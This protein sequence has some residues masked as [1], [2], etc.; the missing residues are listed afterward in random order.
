MI[1]RIGR[2]EIQA[3][4]GRGGFGHV[5]R[6]FDP[7]M[8]SLVAIKRLSGG[9]PELLIRFRNEAAAARKLQHRNIVTVYDFGEEDGVPYIVMELLD[10]ADLQRVIANRQPLSV[11]EKI[12]IMSQVAD[13]LNYAHT[14]GVV[15]R[16]VK[17][18]NIML[19]ADG[20]VKIMD[21]GIALV[22]KATAPRFTPTGMTVG[23]LRYMAPEQ[24]E[25]TVSDSLCDIFSY[26]LV[27]YELLTGTHPFDAAEPAGVIGKILRAEP[28]RIRELCPS[29]P[30]GLEQVV[31]RLLQKERDLRYQSLEDVQFDIQPILLELQRVRGAE[32][33]TRAKDLAARGQVDAAQGLL[34]EILRDDPGNAEARELHGTLQVQAQRKAV[35]ARVEG[36][37]K[38]GQEKMAEQDYGAA[39]ENFESALRLDKLNSDIQALIQQARGAMEQLQRARF[40]VEEAQRALDLRDLT[41]AYQ[42]ATEAL[43]LDPRNAQATL[44]MGEVLREMASRERERRLQQA[45]SRAKG[46]LMLQ[47]FD[48]AISLLTQLEPDYP[49]SRE[50]SELLER[51]RRDKL[52]HERRERL[53]A[54]IAAAKDLL[55]NK[56]PAEAVQRLEQLALDF[57]ETAEVRDLLSYAREELASQRR[58]EKLKQATDEARAL[59]D[60]REFDRAMEILSEALRSFPGEESLSYLLQTTI[61]SKAAFERQAALEEAL[62]NV[63][64]FLAENNYEEALRRIDAFVVWHGNDPA[65]SE[66]RKRARAEWE[67]Q[68]RIQAAGKMMSEARDLL[69]KD[70]PDLATRILRGAKA[71]D[72]DNRELAAL[73][74]IAETRLVEQ[75]RAETVRKV[76]S[77]AAE[78]AGTGQFDRAELLVQETQRQYPQDGALVRCLEATRLARSRY[79]QEQ[80]RQE[81]I[82][83]G[84]QLQREGR[85][86]E[87]ASLIEALLRV[88]PLDPE[89]LTL[90]AA[91][92]AELKE[93]REEVQR[94]SN[95]AR[96][97]MGQH[98]FEPVISL[99]EEHLRRF[100]G[101]PELSLL[102]AQSREL[103]ARQK[104]EEPQYRETAPPPVQAPPV[105]A[106]APPMAGS[107]LR[108]HGRRVAVIAAAAVI[109]GLSIT[110][111]YQRMHPR[112]PEKAPSAELT[113]PIETKSAP[114]KEPIEKPKPENKKAPTA[115]T[116]TTGPLTEERDQAPAIKQNVPAH[117]PLRLRGGLSP[118]AGSG[119]ASGP[120]PDLLP[121][122]EGGP[123]SPGSLPAA[124]QAPP[125]TQAFPK[126]GE[127]N[128]DQLAGTFNL[129]G[130][131]ALKRKDYAGAIAKFTQAIQL[132]PDLAAYYFNRGGT[133][134]QLGS[135]KEAVADFDKTL[136]LEPGNPV[137]TK[138]RNEARENLAA[139]VYR[140]G[141]GVSTPI[142]LQTVPA[143]PTREA[144]HAGTKLPPVKL[145]FVVNERG[146]TE[147]FRIDTPSPYGL[148]Q[149]AI[150]A[151]R[152]WKFSPGKKDGKP[153]AVEVVF[154]VPFKGL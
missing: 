142:P 2:Y 69:T 58:A 138:L 115:E 82:R 30:S 91:I 119:K 134:Y 5:F 136:A 83:K 94:V 127:P 17:P 139:G 101:Q 43:R 149:A 102:L 144:S 135:W 98:F 148:D 67:L 56:R 9:E 46:L 84:S 23:T 4:L 19:L 8:G 71:Q 12:R 32:Q 77:E 48:E 62:R 81:G 146:T 92:E 39:M 73:L 22:T 141:T 6:A 49:E 90:K 132:K 76:V 64:G 66:L 125:I 41:G 97:L 35:R 109:L 114:P 121:P 74:E 18:A 31:F 129:H 55:R 124:L 105:A 110:A 21:F 60:A 75:Q 36:L 33:L 37:L 72:P 85:F 120:A 99:L 123:I 7:T 131:D 96:V 152:R 78:L 140:P 52:V 118:G 10:G 128:R 147:F 143:L 57:P 112:M 137:A 117:P 24:W 68:K 150:E 26:G 27:Y 65:L 70:R 20:N 88:H 51:V 103:Q 29:C 153:V 61:S 154:E 116:K 45:I 54:G 63:Q 145:R 40:L 38:T 95:Q 50:V 59:L 86:A 13:G 80:E 34:R 44:L 106:E 1:N 113:K 16:D 108:G 107:L 53:M 14:H 133:Y 93:Q 151:V 15:H 111:V 122:P 25:G 3:E 87:A 79:Q 100:P 47:S 126:T 130:V 11:L 89:L 42:N 104:A 28:R